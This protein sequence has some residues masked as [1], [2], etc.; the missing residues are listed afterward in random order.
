MGARAPAVFDPLSAL[1]SG[2]AALDRLAEAGH[3]LDRDA[4]TLGSHLR[5]REGLRS[6]NGPAH[7]RISDYRVPSPMAQLLP[8][9]ASFYA[10]LTPVS[11]IETSH[12][13]A[14]E[15]KMRD[16]VR[17]IYIL[18]VTIGVRPMEPPPSG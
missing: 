12:G 11:M 15:D 8:R 13:S 5:G 18:A 3:F 10:R 7:L 1:N 16:L 6:A 14:P 2:D 4:G 9:P 17:L